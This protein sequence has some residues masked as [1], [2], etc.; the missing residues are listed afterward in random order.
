MALTSTD[1]LC[2]IMADSLYFCMYFGF[3]KLLGII[4]ARFNSSRLPGKPVVDI[5]GKPM[6]WWVYNQA[7]KVANIDVIVATDDERVIDVC[8]S[9]NIPSIMTAEHK[10]HIERIAEVSDHISADYYISIN[11]DEPLITPETIQKVIPNCVSADSYVGGLMRA[12]HEPTEVIDPG[13]IK[14]AVN[15]N[16]DCI[17]LSRSPIPFP[18]KTVM[19]DY[20]KLI[21]I[22]CY[23]KA[24]L[25]FMRNTPPGPLERIEDVTLLRYLEHHKSVK[26]TL[27]DEFSLSVDTPRDLE[28]VRAIIADRLKSNE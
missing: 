17:F 27:V 13:N 15:E 8:D 20:Y 18:Y 24:A 5:C 19:Y 11:G 1:R 6:I 25:D 26:Y 28:K 12:M 3:M 10:T 4:P 16:S 21:G 22:E 2:V 14:V 7:I 23:N 9:Y